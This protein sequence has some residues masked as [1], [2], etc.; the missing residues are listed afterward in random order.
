MLKTQQSLPINFRIKS[1]VLTMVDEVL[2]N[3]ALGYLSNFI[4]CQSAPPF[5]CSNHT[6]FLLLPEDTIYASATRIFHSLFSLPGMFL[7]MTFT[8]K[9]SLTTLSKSAHFHLR[10]LTLHCIFKLSVFSTSL[11]T[12]C[13]SDSVCFVYCYFF[14]GLEQYLTHNRHSINICKLINK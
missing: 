14:S 9:S 3:L 11:Y 13:K 7:I 6:G 1:M 8:D 10:I 4:S 12:M 5:R 2:H